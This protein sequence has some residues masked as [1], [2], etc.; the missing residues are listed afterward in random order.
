MAL[1]GRTGPYQTQY[2]PINRGTNAALNSIRDPY[3]DEGLKLLYGRM[4]DQ[5]GP[6]APGKI[7]PATV[8]PTPYTYK[9]PVPQRLLDEQKAKADYDAKVA[10]EKLAYDTKLAA[11]KLAYDAAPLSAENF[12]EADYLARYSDAF[13]DAP[14]RPFAHYLESTG[15]GGTHTAKKLPFTPKPFTPTP[16]V[17][18]PLFGSTAPATPAPVVA[19]ATPVIDAG[20]GGGKAGGIVS[21]D[22]KKRAKIKPRKGLLAA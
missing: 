4:M 16:F 19:A 13:R 14:G 12:D 20:G 3:S 10:A 17:A 1:L 8:A 11:D 6:Q 2:D 15:Q 18:A 7:N 22:R 9:P 5:Y 21:I